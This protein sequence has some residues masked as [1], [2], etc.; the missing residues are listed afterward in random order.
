M[1]LC[2]HRRGSRRTQGAEVACLAAGQGLER[3]AVILRNVGGHAGH[4]PGGGTGGPFPGPPIRP[5]EAGPD[6]LKAGC[7]HVAKD[8]LGATNRP[9]RDR[10]GGPIP[11]RIDKASISCYL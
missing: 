7:R 10:L 4:L 8:A 6:L 5:D 2:R 3:A 11:N 1:K 9:E